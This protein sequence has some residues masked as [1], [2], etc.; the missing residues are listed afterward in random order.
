MSAGAGTLNID[1]SD[2]A[3][4]SSVLTDQGGGMDITPIG[5]VDGVLPSSNDISTVGQISNGAFIGPPSPFTSDPSGMNSTIGG[6]S[7][8]RNPNPTGGW[9]ALASNII[10]SASK[11]FGS[12]VSGSPSA[13]VMAAKKPTGLTTGNVFT[14]ASG[15]TNWALIAVIV[16]AAGVGIYAVVKLA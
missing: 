2:T 12:F 10:G 8:V 14:T 3:G 13:A 5:Q 1:F 16:L 4:I 7:S 11:A 15:T 6:N 9:E